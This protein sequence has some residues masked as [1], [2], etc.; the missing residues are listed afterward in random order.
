MENGKYRTK[1]YSESYLYNKST[2]YEKRL[3]KFLMEAKEV[4][5][6]DPSFEDIISDVK[7]RQVHSV[8][9]RVLMLNSVVLLRHASPL[10]RS[11]KVFAAADVKNGSKAK[12][13]FIDVSDIIMEEDGKY[14]CNMNSIDILGAYLLSALAILINEGKPN[15]IINN[16]QL[17]STG[18]RCFSS[19]FSYIIDYMRLGGVADIREKVTY[20]SAMYYQICILGKEESDSVK[21]LATHLSKLSSRDTEIVDMQME[22]DCYKDI[23]KFVS[24]V[25]KVIKADGLRLDNF[26]EKW[27]MLLGSGTQFGTE[28]Y[29]A[30]SSMLTNAYC[31]VYINNQKT[32]EKITGKNMVE[33]VNTLLR[34]G[35]DLV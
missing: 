22:T 26:V 31:G 27:M 14:K 13:V 34:I 5:K 4:D 19:L 20:M 18:T 32:I 2:D 8:L 25:A 12:K 24:S 28:V 35:G 30:F 9:S 1:G 33:Y 23:D 17:T 16:A 6:K 21:T 29:T 10:P 3:F 11:F 7:R 15:S